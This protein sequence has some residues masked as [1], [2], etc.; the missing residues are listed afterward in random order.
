MQAVILPVSDELTENVLKAVRACSIHF[1]NG[2]MI[3]EMP[4]IAL[5]ESEEY[6][7]VQVMAEVAGQVETPVREMRFYQLDRDTAN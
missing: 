7:L 1:A 6:E 5:S 4:D 2:T 3:V